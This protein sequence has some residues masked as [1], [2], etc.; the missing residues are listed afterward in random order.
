MKNVLIC[1]AAAGAT[2]LTDPATALDIVIDYSYDDIGFFSSS[3]RR[4]VLDQAAASFES[5]LSDDLLAINSGAGNHFNARF[6]D[7]ESTTNGI[8]T[9]PDYSVASDTLIVFVGARQLGGTT[10]GVGG[11][12]FYTVSGSP[13]FADTVETRGEGVTQGGSATDFGP[14]GGSMAFDVDTSWYFDDDASTLEAFSGFDFYS[15]ALHELAHVLGYGQA[16]SWE[17]L[18]SGSN[19]VGPASM[20][21][22]G[23]AVPLAGGAH[24]ANGTVS[25]L[26]D[27]SFQE[28]AMDPSISS[29]SRKY[30]TEL[31]LAGLTDIGWQVAA[32][33]EPAEW[34]MLL[35]GLALVAGASRRRRGF[36]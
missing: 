16:D 1:M 9:L 10:L 23:S 31:D 34:A 28:V 27:G 18:I 33:P 15:V 7:P 32:V 17:N 3:S 35:G 11:S 8:I 19:F 2:L 6:F 30:L 20:D 12:G 21:A 24:W 22:F 13:A 5:I 25:Q 36:P 14:W 4:S 29:G 26:P